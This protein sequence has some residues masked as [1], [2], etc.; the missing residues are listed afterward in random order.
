MVDILSGVNAEDSP[1]AIHVRIAPE[2]TFRSYTA[3]V[4]THRSS[5]VSPRDSLNFG[6]QSSL[7]RSS[8]LLANIL[9]QIR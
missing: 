8:R 7:S 5:T 1:K 4:I 9:E 2:Q 6:L 3:M